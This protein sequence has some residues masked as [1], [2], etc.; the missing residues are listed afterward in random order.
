MIEKVFICSFIVFAI[1]YSMQEGEIFGRLGRWLE[2]LP[3]WMHNPVFDCPVCMTPWYGTVIYWIVWGGSVKE[4]LVV[5]I[6]AMGLSAI[7]VKFWTYD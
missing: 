2:N 6:A 4:W 3:E 5:I 1:W 7:I